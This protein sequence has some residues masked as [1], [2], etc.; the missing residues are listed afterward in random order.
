MSQTGSNHGSSLAEETWVELGRI[1]S[2]SR[3]NFGSNGVK[4]WD[5]QGRSG[6]KES[7]HWSNR[8]E[9]RNERGLIMSQTRS[10]THK[11]NRLES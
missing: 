4:S 9:S 7:N 5:N 8:V 3:S 2:R 1:M 6:R 10:T 11:S